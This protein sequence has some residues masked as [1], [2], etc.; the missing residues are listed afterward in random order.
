MNALQNLKLTRERIAGL[1]KIL[2]QI[3]PASG[4]SVSFRHGVARDNE[5]VEDDEI[6]R[7]WVTCEIGGIATGENVAKLL[8][9]IT[10]KALKDL[11]TFWMKAVQ[12]DMEEMNKELMK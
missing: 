5:D 12:R 1:K 9:E 2:L 6:R 3:D 8:I 4:L 11:E 10:L 7:P